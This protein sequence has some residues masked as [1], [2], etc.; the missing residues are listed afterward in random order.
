MSRK[1]LW[2]P[3]LLMVLALMIA[4]CGGTA[5]TE[6]TAPTAAPAPAEEEAAPAEEEAAPAESTGANQLEFYSWWTAGGEADGLNAMYDLFKAMYPDIEIVNATVAGGAWWSRR[7]GHST[8]SATAG[9]GP[10]RCASP[11][12]PST[13]S[14]RP[15]WRM[16]LRWRMTNRLGRIR[17]EGS[18]P[19]ATDNRPQTDRR[20]FRKR[21]TDDEWTFRTSYFV[22]RTSYFFFILHSS[23]VHWIGRAKIQGSTRCRGRDSR[24]RHQVKSGVS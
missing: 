5:P 17:N 13:C 2:L 1:R 10:L 22:L 3:I 21:M 12:R 23:F 24:G 6:T 19:P 9:R 18:R 4:A 8:T 16:M 14:L 7:N 15:I 11:A 20:D